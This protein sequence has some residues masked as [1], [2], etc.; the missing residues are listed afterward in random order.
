MTAP[1]GNVY[2]CCHAHT[3]MGSVLRADFRAIWNG[4]QLQ[5]LRRTFNGG[6]LPATCRSCNFIRSGRLSGAELVLDET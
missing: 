5:A 3:P 4:P 1:C 2:P 6:A